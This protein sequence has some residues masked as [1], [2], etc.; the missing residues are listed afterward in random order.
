MKFKF[1]DLDIFPKVRNDYIHQTNFGGTVTFISVIIMIYLFFSETISFFFSPLHQRLRIDNT[2]LPIKDGHLD[3]ANQSKLEI[4][5]DLMLNNVPCEF[6]DYGILDEYKDA[7]PN[8]VYDIKLHTLDKDGRRVKV[9][10]NTRAN[11]GC[12]SCYGL[13][14]GCC[15]SCKEVKKAFKSKNRNLPPLHTIE[16]CRE[17]VKNIGIN[18]QCHLFGKILAPKVGGTIYIAPGDS[19]SDKSKHIADYMAMNITVD[20]FNMSHVINHI[21]FGE[22]QK[23]A[24]KDNACIQKEKGRFKSLYFIKTAKEIKNGKEIYRYSATHYERYREGSSLKFP[25][26][27]I[28]YDSSPII[29]EY[30]RD[31]SVL[32]FLVELMGILGG[33]IAFASFIERMELTIKNK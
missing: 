31:V 28:F 9:K 26:I 16:Q 13:K 33:V 12:G 2:P 25:G 21:Y 5:I 10:D 27:F 4:H 32:H 15:N 11:S 19:Y 24:I 3:V 1:S 30:K 22:S 20:D 8:V 17:S 23:G 7:M 18:Q 6:V 14:S 29:A